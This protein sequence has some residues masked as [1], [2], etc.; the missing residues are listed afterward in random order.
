MLALLRGLVPETPLLPQDIY[1]QTSVFR[2]DIR[3]GHSATEA[4]IQHLQTS[5]IMHHILKD[6]DSNR[7]KGLFITCPESAAPLQYPHPFFTTL[8]RPRSC[9]S[10]KCL[11]TPSSERM[12]EENAN[13]G[14]PRSRLI[15]AEIQ[16]LT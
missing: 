5:G 14:G 2:R 10:T 6:P 11:T 8:F 16:A 15:M 7:L 1:N 9:L 4:L 3:Q 13:T 12:E